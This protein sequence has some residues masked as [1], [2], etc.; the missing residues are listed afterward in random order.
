LQENNATVAKD[1]VYE[2]QDIHIV[3][4]GDVIALLPA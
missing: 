4:F 1:A 3:S 2:Q